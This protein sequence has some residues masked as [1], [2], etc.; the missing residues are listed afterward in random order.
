MWGCEK[1]DLVETL[2]TGD[3]GIVVPTEITLGHHPGSAPNLASPVFRWPDLLI[4]RLQTS[5]GGEL[6]MKIE[7]SV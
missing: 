1:T 4:V 7:N 2:L 3:D 6:E 5:A